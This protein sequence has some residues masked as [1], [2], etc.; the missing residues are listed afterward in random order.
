MVPG[1][2]DHMDSRTGTEE[3]ID[4]FQIPLQRL[5]MAQISG[6]EETVY[7]SVSGPGDHLSKRVLDSLG[8]FPAPGLIAVRFHAPVDIGGMDEF[9]GDTS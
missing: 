3:V 7:L 9:H 6:D 4:L 5:T 2:H 1:N 8:A